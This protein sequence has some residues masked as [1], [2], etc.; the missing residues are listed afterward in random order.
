MEI[1]KLD[2]Q[3]RR[4]ELELLDVFTDVET[5]D[6]SDAECD[7]EEPIQ[8]PPS[9]REAELLLEK[10][11]AA[12]PHPMRDVEYSELYS[13]ADYKRNVA[14]KMAMM[15]RLA[16]REN[17]E[18]AYRDVRFWSQLEQV[19]ETYPDNGG[20]DH[21]DELVAYYCYTDNKRNEEDEDDEDTD[22]DDDDDEADDVKRIKLDDAERV[23]PL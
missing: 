11:L 20:R 9:S 10:I 5:P 23:A 12:K 19:K 1:N 6:G 15:I 17:F 7:S 18:E 2:Q 22:D 16:K 8:L 14:K 21:L 3:E 13:Y 4:L